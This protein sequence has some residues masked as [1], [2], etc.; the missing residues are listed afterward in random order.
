MQFD[1][2]Q[3]LDFLTLCK[4]TYLWPHCLGMIAQFIRRIEED[5]NHQVLFIDVNVAG[6]IRSKND[7]VLRSDK[8]QLMHIESLNTLKLY[9]HKYRSYNKVLVIGEL[10]F[11]VILFLNSASPPFLN[12]NNQ[13]EVVFRGLDHWNDLLEYIQMNQELIFLFSN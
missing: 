1:W 9:L 13:I 4:I 8:L 10:L 6:I 11:P 2:V 7:S 12:L 3:I 5:H